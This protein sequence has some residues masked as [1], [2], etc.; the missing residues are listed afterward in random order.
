MKINVAILEKDQVYLNRL[1]SHLSS[2]YTDKLEIYSFT[3]QDLAMESLDQSKIDVFLSSDDFNIDVEDIPSRCGFAYFVESPEIETYRDQQA[4]SKY[5]KLDLIYRQLLSIYSEKAGTVTGLKFTEDDC[6]VVCFSS[7]SG[8]VGSSTMAAAC[9]KHFSERG[10]KVLYLNL[11]RFGSADLYFDGEGQFNMSDIIFAL[12]S[13]K[14]NLP[15]KLES[16]VKEDESGVRFYSES[17][18]ALDMH[19]LD[20]EDLLRLIQT[21]R[22]TQSYDFLVLDMDFYLSKSS[23]QLFRQFHSFIIVGDGSET[24]NNKIERAYDA[25]KA[26]EQSEDFPVYKRTALLY[27]KFSSK[28]GDILEMGVRVLGGAP[29]YENATTQQILER[30]AKLEVFQETFK[31]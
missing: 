24:S 4:I 7:P 20:V 19:E 3:K 27:N 8:G 11:E 6:K 2:Q 28:T 29:R 22:L 10:K 25:I 14:A 16:S 26:L 15:M 12:K 5:Q 30:L 1:V 21:I 31:E 9:A 17:R 13:Q 18:L 23:V